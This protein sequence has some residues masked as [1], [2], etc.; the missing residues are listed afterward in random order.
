MRYVVLTA[1][2]SLAALTYIQ[3]QGFVAASP[4]IKKDLDLS[5]EQMGY[6][7]AVW[8]LAYGGF[9]V[10]GGF[11]GDR[12][13]ARRLL[14]ILVLNWSLTSGAVALT[15][16]CP[17]WGLSPFGLLLGLRFLFGLLQ[18]GGFPVLARVLAD[19]MPVRQRGFA[20]GLVWT[21]SRLGGALAP[22][23]LLWL[24]NFF[25]AWDTPLLLIAGLGL[26]WCALFWPW[27]RNRPDDMPQVNPAERDL[28][29]LGRCAAPVPSSSFPWQ[30]FLTSIN[31]WALCL[32]YGC[33]GFTG[34]FITN[35]LP[36]YLHDH[37]HLSDDT[38]AWLSAL[39]IACGIV[40]CL[41]GGVVSD[42]LIG[43]LGSRV[44]GRRL[45]GCAV[46]SLAGLAVLSSLWAHET[47]LL[48]IAVSAWFFFN[49]ANMA[50]AWASC[51]DVGEQYAGTLSGAMNMMGSLFGA[52]GAAFAGACFHRGQYDVVFI[53]FASSYFLAALCWLAINVAKPL[54]AKAPL[55][56]TKC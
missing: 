17:A 45:V 21:F 28:I 18:A 47:W 29:A 40:S 9:Q 4:F 38:T 16:F 19:W 34:N 23:V 5:T 44:W 39:P 42:W 24:L 10:L 35:L 25:G 14:T 11:L 52:A 27:F 1:A 32:M 46:L 22:L 48:A 3:R 36:I 51:A 33:V 53:V 41:F 56:G 55:R 49:D 26:L 7:A 12:F 20:Q 31:V 30:R 43:R 13:G 6:L 8:L 15:L 37:L 2:C 54:V 50:P